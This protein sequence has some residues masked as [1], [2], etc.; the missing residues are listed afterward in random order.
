MHIM[1][2]NGSWLINQITII[3]GGR[4]SRFPSEAQVEETDSV[5]LLTVT[6][7]IDADQH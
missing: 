7:T 2:Y 6:A 1:F 4:L 5:K 3:K